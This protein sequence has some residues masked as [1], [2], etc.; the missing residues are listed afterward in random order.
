MNPED[1]FTSIPA[2]LREPLL[3]EYGSIVANYS[4][5]RWSPAELS[6][7]L[8]CEIVYAILSGHAANNFAR[9]PSKPSNFV[10]ACRG[11]EQNSHVPRSFQILIPR[12]LPALYEVRNNRGVGHVGGDVDPNHMD[13]TFV[14]SSANWIMCELIRVFHSL[15]ICEAQ[16]VVDKLSEIRVP[17][18]WVKG[19]VRRVLKPGMKQRQQ[20]LILLASSSGGTIPDLIGWLEVSNR[21]YLMKTLR[22]MHKE[23]LLELNETSRLIELLPPGARMAENL[24]RQLTET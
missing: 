23:R 15:P 20:I 10:S 2:G 16:E 24:V 21:A 9:V 3:A 18:V 6:G 5:H 19:D 11:L 4:E 7:G 13:A 17:L 12:L 8:F 1:V 14:L 22:G